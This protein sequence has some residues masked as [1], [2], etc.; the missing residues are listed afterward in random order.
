L[1]EWKAACL[2]VYVESDSSRLRRR[3]RRARRALVEHL[4]TTIY[5]GRETHQEL[6]CLLNASA[7][8]ERLE[9]ASRVAPFPARTL[10]K[11]VARNL[12]MQSAC[13]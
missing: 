7:A 10:T 13:D 11:R 8:L 12:P 9:E 3:V 2:A 4:L 5:E 6:E 1:P